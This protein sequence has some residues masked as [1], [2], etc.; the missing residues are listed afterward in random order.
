MNNIYFLLLVPI[1]AS[2]IGMLIWSHKLTITEFATGIIV[3]CL[4]TTGVYFMTMYSNMHDFELINGHITGKQKNWTSCSHSYTCNCRTVRTGK[5]TT[6]SCSICYEHL[7]DWDWDVMTT[8]GNFTVDRVDRRGSNEPPRWTQVKAG[9]PVAVERSYTNYIKGA[10]HSIFNKSEMTYMEKY[11]N[12]I[13]PY[14]EV[15]DYHR[16]NRVLSVGSPIQNLPLWNQRLSEVLKDLGPKKQANVVILFTKETNIGFA[17]AVNAKW[18]GG[19]KNDIVLIVSTIDGKSINWVRVLA[20]TNTTRIKTYL[21]DDIKNG[22]VDVERFMHAISKNVI[23]Y[24][25]RKSMEQFK[26]LLSSMELSMTA[27]LIIAVLSFL[28]SI[29]LSFFFARPDINFSLVSL[30]KQHKLN[31]YGR[32]YR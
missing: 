23:A 4:M 16:A 8:V 18:L 17:E 14:P 25:D 22:D 21:R 2:I 20:L 9:E 10:P 15:Y 24:Y 11:N 29:G 31:S 7:N 6:T 13:P 32:R 1:F 28:C 30:F 19:K 27:T 3:T 26:Y 12:M 5:T